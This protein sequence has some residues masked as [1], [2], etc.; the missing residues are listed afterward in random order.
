MAVA[1]GGIN[2]GAAVAGCGGVCVGGNAVG[3][4]EGNGLGKTLGV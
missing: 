3:L 2:V 1:V 4:G